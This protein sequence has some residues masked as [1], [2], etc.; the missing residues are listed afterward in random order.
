MNETSKEDNNVKTPKK[1]YK[2]I[3]KKNHPP[4]INHEK[5]EL[6]KANLEYKE[7][8]LR[9]TAEM[10]NMRRRYELDYANVLKY[11]GFDIVEKLLPV[12]DNFERAL[13]L[14]IEG[15]EKFLEGFQMIYNSFI[16]IL[17]GKGIK[18]IEVL[19]KPFDPNI[20][21]AVMTEVNNDVEENTVLDCL[22]KGYM[23][24]DKLIRPAM[25]KV[26]ERND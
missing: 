10:Q 23:Y 13:K 12:I 6:I 19:N 9:L 20:M 2:E 21:N 17:N 26:S 22:Q 25:V 8:V 3:K 14:K 1:N 24:N 18:E 5:D 11:D 15:Q 7:R 4:K 16:E